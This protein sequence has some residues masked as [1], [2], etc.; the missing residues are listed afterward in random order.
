MNINIEILSDYLSQILIDDFHLSISETEKYEAP[1]DKSIIYGLVCLHEDLRYYKTRSKLT[2]D[3]LKKALF[4]S[5]AVTITNCNNIVTEINSLFLDI[6][7][8]SEH[9]VLGK[10]CDFFNSIAHDDVYHKNIRDTINSGTVWRGE[11]CNTKKNGEI[12]WVNTNIFPIKDHQGNIHEFWSIRTDITEKKKVELELAQ[13]NKELK[14][15]LKIKDYLIKEMHHR[16]K[17]NLQFLSSMLSIKSRLGN[18]NEAELIKEIIN[19]I[20]SISSLH[21]ILYQKA[22]H[23]NINLK[24][25]LDKTFNVSHFNLN[26]NLKIKGNNLMTSIET[27]SYIGV[28]INELITNSNKYAWSNNPFSNKQI[29]ISYK[30]QNDLLIIYYTDNGSGFTHKNIKPG[31]GTTLISKLISKQ[32]NG[33]Y[34]ENND[35]GYGIEINIPKQDALK[36]H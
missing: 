18:E 27:C 10:T 21:E 7:G 34:K 32:L 2:I 12:Y 19:R 4:N 3:N 30:A 5:A 33:T 23:K 35:N 6:S 26:S 28:I 22:E 16:I 11:L 17:N 24:E 9:E 13:K 14:E 1:E 25:Y 15:A 8:Y 36:L 20:N 31:L 29:Q